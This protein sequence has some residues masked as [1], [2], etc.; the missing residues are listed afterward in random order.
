[1]LNVVQLN[2]DQTAI[3]RMARVLYEEF[4]ETLDTQFTSFDEA[5]NAMLSNLCEAC[6]KAYHGIEW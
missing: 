5:N 2:L 4:K 3:D 1:M 6:I